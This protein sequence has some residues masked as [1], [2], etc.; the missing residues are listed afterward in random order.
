MSEQILDMALIEELREVLE[1]E[2]NQIVDAFITQAEEQKPVL[3]SSYER[4]DLLELS[5]TVHLIKGSAANL[6]AQALATAAAQLELAA[7]EQNQSDTDRLLQ[8][9]W[10]VMEETIQQ[11]QTLAS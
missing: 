4:G 1:S 6:G 3:Q 2:F 10:P 8:G 7:R 11:L 9:L 5:K